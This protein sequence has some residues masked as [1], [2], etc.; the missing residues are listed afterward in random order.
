MQQEDGC[1]NSAALAQAANSLVRAAGFEGDLALE[2][3]PGGGNNRVYRVRS[4]SRR[5]LLKAYFQH[6]ADPR[7]RLG[8]E[9]AFSSFAWD[10]GITQLPR[11]LG[12]DRQNRLALYEFVDGRK[13]RP[14]EVT[15]Q[16]VRQALSFFQE[17][18]RSKRTPAAKALPEASE[19]GFSLADHLR[20]VERRVMRLREIEDSTDPTW[21]E[22]RALA[23]ELHQAWRASAV[24]ILLQARH[25][26]LDPEQPLAPADRCI[27]PSDFGFHNALLST[28]GQLKFLDFEYAGWDD[29]VRMICD[30]FCQPAV[31]V[32][33]CHFD[34]FADAVLADLPTPEVQR[35][36]LALM[37]SVYQMKWCCIMLNVFQPVGRQRRRFAI[38]SA[39]LEIQ[40]K[41]QLAQARSARER[42]RLPAQ[43]M[44]AESR[45]A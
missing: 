24:A 21:H 41:R 29:P 14:G 26:G 36:R 39:E 27:S 34:A 6:P 32:P 42:L 20:M 12:C 45:N 31:P 2:P 40:A 15:A 16:A 43:E 13:L 44:L 1:L 35:R 33:L 7:D 23:I 19:A 17:L 25:M 38:D 9:F 30:F 18:N 10:H 5:A 37:F 3:M 22:A 11:P 8:A 28:S 4:E